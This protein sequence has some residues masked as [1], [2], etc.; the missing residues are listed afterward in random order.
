M[1]QN[2]KTRGKEVVW[3]IGNWNLFGF[4]NLGFGFWNTEQNKSCD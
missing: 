3:Q 4:W 1:T 2:S